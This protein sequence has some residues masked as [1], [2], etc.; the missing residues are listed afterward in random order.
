M[1][2][3]SI[4]NARA[5]RSRVR[6]RRARRRRHRRRPHRRRSARRRPASRA[7]AHDRCRG[8]GRRARASSTCAARLREPGHE[9]EAHARDRRCAAAVAGGVTSARL[10][11]RH[12][13]AARRAGPGRDAQVPR[14][15]TSTRPRVYPL[16]A[17][18]V[19]LKGES[20]DRDGR[21]HRGRLR[22]LLAGRRADA[23]TPLVL[24]AARCSTRR[25]SATRSGCA[26]T[27]PGSAG[28]VAAEGRGRHAPGPRRRARC[29]PRPSRWRTIFELV[30]DTGARVHLCR[31][32]AAPPAS[33]WCAA[34][35]ARGPA[36]HLR[37]R[38][39][40]TLHLIDVDIGY[41][42]AA[43]PPGAAAAPAA[44]PR[45]DPRRPR[46]R[47]DRRAGRD[48]TPVDE[49]E[50][51]LPFAEA[52]PGATGLELLLGLALSGA[53]RPASA[54]AQTLARGDEP[55]VRRA[56]PA[57]AARPRGAGAACVEG[58]PADLC[59]FDPTISWQLDASRLAQPQ[60]A[61]ARSIGNEL[62]GRV[63][64]TLV[65]GRVAHDAGADAWLALGPGASSAWRCAAFAPSR[66]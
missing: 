17:L 33:S 59:V 64:W 26:R 51:H 30:R 54:L 60:P 20:A 21:A 14:A 4:R 61:H 27:T 50:K 40:T 11:A 58:A 53:R 37:R 1:N 43:M 44:R 28:G 9:H 13:S 32:S 38:R 66:A 35:K 3:R 12:R 18:T 55:A 36:G 6:P 16:G 63:R 29:S 42:D 62:P 57:P 46:R 10:P 34:A 52:E 49:D 31:L 19:G 2:D 47:H 7:D 39:S 65:A 23:A 45:R 56:R 8:A 48:H 41:F 5:G 25:P 24:H 22:R 15:A